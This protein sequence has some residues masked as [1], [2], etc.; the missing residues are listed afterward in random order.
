MSNNLITK[1]LGFGFVIF[2]VAI[3][4]IAITLPFGTEIKT[5]SM[6]SEVI[7]TLVNPISAIIGALLR[8]MSSEK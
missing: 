8:G 5:K 1:I 3:A 7:S 6:N 2:A 4:V